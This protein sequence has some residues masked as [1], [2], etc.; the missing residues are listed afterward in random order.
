VDRRGKVVWEMKNLKLPNSCQRIDNGNTLISEFDGG[1]VIE[2]DRSGKVV[3]SYKV[4]Y[5]LH[6]RRLP[7]GHTVICAA[8]GVFEIDSGA[9]VLWEHKV[10]VGP[11]YLSAY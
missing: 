2:V 7:D 1:R 4:E 11:F 8:V 3:W 9:N 5:P 10:V 6:A